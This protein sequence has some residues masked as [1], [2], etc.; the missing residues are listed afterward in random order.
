M[1]FRRAMNQ[2]NP[3]HAPLLTPLQCLRLQHSSCSTSKSSSSS[4]CSS[5]LPPAARTLAAGMASAPS[6]HV[7][8]RATLNGLAQTARYENALPGTN[9]PETHLLQIRCTPLQWSVPMRGRA[10]PLQARAR[11]FEVALSL[12]CY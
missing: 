3:R 10:I 12:A 7:H 2:T 8:A 4:T 6:A 9:G 11:K 1:S 5:P